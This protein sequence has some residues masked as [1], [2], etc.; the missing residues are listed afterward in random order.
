[1]DC[2]WG[3]WKLFYVTIFKIWS[4]L[5][6][7]FIMYARQTFFVTKH[8]LVLFKRNFRVNVKLYSDK[9]RVNGTTIQNELLPWHSPFNENRKPKDPENN[10]GAEQRTTKEFNPGDTMVGGYFLLPW[11]TSGSLVHC[12]WPRKLNLCVESSLCL[13]GPSDN[14]VNSPRSIARQIYTRKG[15]PAL[16]H[17]NPSALTTYYSACHSIKSEC[18]HYNLDLSLS[19][20]TPVFWG[21]LHSGDTEF[22]P[23][24]TFLLIFDSNPTAIHGK[25][26]LVPRVSLK[27]RFYCIFFQKKRDSLYLSYQFKSKHWICFKTRKILNSVTFKLSFKFNAFQKGI[28][29]SWA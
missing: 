8:L 23:G 20:G 1:M 17:F 11:R 19:F 25:S 22:G 28:N 21:N 10:L 9:G 26:A 14:Y 18:K 13:S 3:F 6:I 16:V 12:T 5:F 7:A 24:K 4:L 29:N 27:W 15:L 2:D